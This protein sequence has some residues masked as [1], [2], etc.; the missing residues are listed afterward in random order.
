MTQLQAASRSSFRK[1]AASR[2]PRRLSCV[3]YANEFR[4]F[5]IARTREVQFRIV[6][7]AI[8]LF[9][10]SARFVARTFLKERNQFAVASEEVSVRRRDGAKFMID[11][12]KSTAGRD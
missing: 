1:L 11:N 3:F 4:K 10:R 2:N 12:V 6:S 5:L 8:E 9:V 7:F